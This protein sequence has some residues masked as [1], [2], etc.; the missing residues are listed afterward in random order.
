[1]FLGS[2]YREDIDDIRNSPSQ[3]LI[4]KIK[5]YSDL[6]TI[7]DPFNKINKIKLERNYLKKFDI[8]IFCVKHNQIRKM[9]FKSI[10]NIRNTIFDL[11]HVIPKILKKS[12]YYKKRIFVLG[13][14]SVK[15]I[16]ITEAQD[17]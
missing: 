17:L 4:K 1:M 11:N 9:N 14:Y 10:L 6:I 3:E 5:K 12:K 2:T 15:R 7:Y 16:L 8:L 13:D